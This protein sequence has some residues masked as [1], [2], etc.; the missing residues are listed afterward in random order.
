MSLNYIVPLHLDYSHLCGLGQ[1]VQI[2]KSLHSQKYEKIKLNTQHWI[3]ITQEL[4]DSLRPLCSK[5]KICQSMYKNVLWAKWLYINLFQA[6]TVYVT[7]LI[8]LQ[9]CTNRIVSTLFQYICFVWWGK[10]VTDL[11]GDKLKLVKKNDT[12]KVSPDHQKIWI[13]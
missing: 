11:W 13:I 6:A 2:I 12:R 7:N 4:N 8:I 5:G 10:V 1:I 9:S 3:N